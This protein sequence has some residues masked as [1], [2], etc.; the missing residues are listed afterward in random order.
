MNSKYLLLFLI[1]ISVSNCKKHSNLEAINTLD[2]RNQSKI[3]SLIGVG[4]TSGMTDPSSINEQSNLIILRDSIF[5]IKSFNIQSGSES[6][7]TIFRIK[8]DFSG[9]NIFDM[10]P[11]EHL[12]SQTI[13]S[14]GVND[15]SDW[16]IA[17]EFKKDSSIIWRMGKYAVPKELEDFNKTLKKIW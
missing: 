8:N 4:V 10:I 14:F 11:K 2:K 12:K 5:K 1:I 15:G 7:N 13:G 16:L 9:R 17:I 3:I 6:Q